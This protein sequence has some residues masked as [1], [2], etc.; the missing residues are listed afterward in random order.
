MARNRK[1][2]FKFCHSIYIISKQFKKHESYKHTID[3]KLYSTV[4]LQSKINKL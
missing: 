4:L 3:A 2:N 1:S